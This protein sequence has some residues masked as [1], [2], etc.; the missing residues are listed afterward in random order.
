[1]VYERVTLYGLP[2]VNHRVVGYARV[3]PE[4]AR[5]LFL[6]HAL[7]EGDWNAPHR[8][9][10]ENQALLG[11]VEELEH[12][13]R[14][15]DLVVDADALERLYDERVPAHVVSGRHFDSW[16]KKA[17]RAQPDLL[18][19]AVEDLLEG[20]AD[21]L[22]ESDFPA[23]W[24]QDGLALGLSYAFTPG[25]ADD[26]VAV[27]I[28]IVLLNQVRPTGFDWQVPGLR[29][30]LVCELIRSL[31]KPLRRNLVP[32]PQT[33]RAFLDRVEPMSS[34]LLDAL[35]RDLTKVG[36]ERIARSRLGSG[37]PARSSATHIPGRRR[38]GNR[39]RWRRG[40]PGDQGR[41]L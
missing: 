13:F 24:L 6:R 25:T 11:E 21:D 20:S 26:G 22:I 17:R 12:R 29:E 9:I 19:F 2:I 30:E 27:H 33:A 36:G 40:P 3:D 31:P 28:P 38:G 10:K 32:I 5:E 16:W 4:H 39:A 7:V 14:R 23:E 37:S 34:P 18:T 1:M 15:G 35:E 41:A 8:F